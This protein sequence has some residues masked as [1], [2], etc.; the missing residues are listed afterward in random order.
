MKAFIGL[1]SN[2]G[3]RGMYLSQ[4]RECLA[5]SE[6]VEIRQQSRIY[7]SAPWGHT[8][9]PDFWNQVVEIETGLTARALL[10]LCHKIESDLGR[11]RQ[12]RWGSR[13]IDLDL[14]LYEGVSCQTPELILPHPEIE[15]RAFVLVPL[16]EIAPELILP[17]GRP[18]QNVTGTGEVRL[19]DGGIK[20]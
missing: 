8:E 12:I 17:S 4:A 5:G 6:E 19:L 15:N 10:L 20:A 11:K 3:D 14:L 9:Q 7:V 13:T 2:L 16:R 1:G 18:I